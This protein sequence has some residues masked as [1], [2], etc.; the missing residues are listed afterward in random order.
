VDSWDIFD[1]FPDHVE[2][3]GRMIS[4]PEWHR[5]GLRE[6]CFELFG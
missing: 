1:R 2:R 6:L 3:D 5:G 4:L